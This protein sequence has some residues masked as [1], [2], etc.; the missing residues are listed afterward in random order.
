MKSMTTPGGVSCSFEELK[1]VDIDAHE[2]FTK[3]PE[4]LDYCVQSATFNH[5]E[6]AEYIIYIGDD[7]P[8]FED[9]LVELKGLV[10]NDFISI[11][12]VAKK[13]GA[14]WL[15]LHDGG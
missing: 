2:L 6:S 3:Y 5:K 13:R 14:T 8:S 9:F 15:M 10:S 7:P 4:D 12:R 1:V 11:L